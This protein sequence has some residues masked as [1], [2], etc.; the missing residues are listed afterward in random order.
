MDWPCGKVIAD[1]ICQHNHGMKRRLLDMRQQ[2][3]AYCKKENCG[4]GGMFRFSGEE[5]TSLSR[6]EGEGGGEQKCGGTEHSAAVLRRESVAV[7]LGRLV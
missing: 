3:N 4:L 7:G 1:Y 2:P 5:S 6:R